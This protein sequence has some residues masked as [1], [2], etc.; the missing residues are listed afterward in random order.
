MFQFTSILSILIVQLP[1]I[2][3]WVI[4]LVLAIIRWKRHPRASLFTLIAIT[5]LMI[6]SLAGSL[7]SVWLPVMIRTGGW[8]VSR[9]GV[10]NT[11]V[12]FVRSL[13]AAILWGL[14]LAAIFGKRNENDQE[15]VG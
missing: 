12:G 11:A 15:T 5:G 14:L 13:L 8:D 1:L 2:L 10:I 3:V 9:I 7:L 4:G 6:L